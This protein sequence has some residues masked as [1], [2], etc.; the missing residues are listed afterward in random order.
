MRVTQ[1]NAW[2]DGEAT[3]AVE[4][5][6][7]DVHNKPAVGA[8]VH[9]SANNGAKVA[10]ETVQTDANGLA[11]TTVTST[12]ENQSVTVTAKTQDNEQSI[13]VYFTDVPFEVKSLTVS[14]DNAIADNQSQDVV[15]LVMAKY[16][17]GA[18]YLRAEISG[19]A[20]FTD[21]KTVM[22]LSSQITGVS[23]LDLPV[24]SNIAGT[25]K[26]TVI[27]GAPIMNRKVQ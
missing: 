3:N 22:D 27:L 21:G 10:Q 23:H 8:E 17:A 2:A 15:H 5:L 20:T 25:S 19:G 4:V 11:S 24:I 1:N 12:M 16:S 26:V 13:D 6:V 14:P 18:P 9:F 7:T